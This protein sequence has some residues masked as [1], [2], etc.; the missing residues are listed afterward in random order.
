MDKVIPGKSLLSGAG[1]TL[2]PLLPL[3]ISP[4]TK[5]KCLRLQALTENS[6]ATALNNIIYNN[7]TLL[8]WHFFL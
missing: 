4:A 7:S 8:S 5:G 3:P 1:M 2:T 6:I